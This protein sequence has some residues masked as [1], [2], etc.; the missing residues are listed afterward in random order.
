M[1]MTPTKEREPHVNISL[2]LHRK[3]APQFLAAKIST[4][5]AEG[6]T[7]FKLRVRPGRGVCYPN[8][9]VPIA[10][11]I[12]YFTT[13]HGCSF[14]PAASW[15]NVPVLNQ[16]GTLRPYVHDPLASPVTHL[17]K[18]WKFSSDD[19]HDVVHGIIGSMRRAGEM[20]QGVLQGL[21]LALYEV[22]DN[23]LLHSQTEANSPSATGYV[24]AQYHKS[25]Q[26]IAVA[27]FD[28][29]Q[30]IPSSLAKGGIR[31]S[32]P[33]EALGVAIQRG[34]GDGAGA[35][36]GLWMMERIVSRSSGSFELTSD[37]ARYAVRHRQ[38]SEVAAPAVSSVTPFKS[39]T[40]L[41]DF[42][43]HTSRPL[44]IQAALDT[45]P[46]NLWI[47]NHLVDLPTSSNQPNEALLV[48]VA[49]ESRGCA[50]RY[51][52][53]A[54]ANMAGNLM[55]STPDVCILDFNGISMVSASYADELLMRLI[56]RFGIITVIQRLS[57]KGLSPTN[58]AMFDRCFRGRLFGPSSQRE[59]R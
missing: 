19:H 53:K 7:S 42:Q 47:D 23:I 39:G 9:C 45:D 59:S 26:R 46:I 1:S 33:S 5:I 25:E 20:P 52:A 18:V 49:K 31:A 38:D 8:I 40:T 30:G 58:A 35:G 27:V 21:E 6:I 44:D 37:G 29:G 51:E 2:D 11:I 4:G 55:E 17:N 56:D 16:S 50:S 57:F 36:N 48:S 28:L 10:G 12:D 3:G 34:V 54:F 41:V 24:M 13:E 14:F 32:S 22:T 15:R 43:L